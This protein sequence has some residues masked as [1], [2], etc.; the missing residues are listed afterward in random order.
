MS[1]CVA[2]TLEQSFHSTGEYIEDESQDHHYSVVVDVKLVRIHGVSDLL[3]VLAVH[4]HGE[5]TTCVEEHRKSCSCVTDTDYQEGPHQPCFF[6]I[7]DSKTWQ[8]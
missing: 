3:L 4:G 5:A 7:F 1:N 8:I 6:I 2:L